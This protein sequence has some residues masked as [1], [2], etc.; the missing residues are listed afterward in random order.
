MEKGKAKREKWWRIDGE[1]EQ[2]GTKGGK[3]EKERHWENR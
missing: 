1:E 3:K 2:M